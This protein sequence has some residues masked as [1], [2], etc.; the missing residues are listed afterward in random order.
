ML[1]TSSAPDAGNP[2][3]WKILKLTKGANGIKLANA[4]VKSVVWRLVIGRTSYHY[5]VTGIN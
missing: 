2:V 3:L 1:T 5:F 4:T